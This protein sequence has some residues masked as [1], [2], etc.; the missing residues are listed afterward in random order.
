MRV[1]GLELGV[2]VDLAVDRVDEAVQALAGAHVHAVG[3]DAQLVLRRQ[4]RDREP[5]GDGDLE[6]VEL[7]AVERHRPYGFRRK[8][9]PHRC[10]GVAGAEAREGV[11]AEGLV[12]RGEIEVHLVGLDVE[13]SGAFARLVTGQVQ[14]GHS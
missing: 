10:T 8:V 11:G 5:A 1:V 9:D 4:P 13:Q 7:L 2:E 14:A 12:A 3:D 6:R